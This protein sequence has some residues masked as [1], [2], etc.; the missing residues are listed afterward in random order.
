[1]AVPIDRA[2]VLHIAQLAQL[3][4]R[5]EE[6]E[7]FAGELSAIV[8]YVEK[9]ESLDT[10]GIEPTAHIRAG[11]S[12]LREDVVLPGLSRED[13]LAQAPRAEHDGFAVPPFVE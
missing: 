6:V 9:L 2:R 12:A 5:E 3:S 7:R 8:A 11:G 13:A 4:L 10:T 1:M